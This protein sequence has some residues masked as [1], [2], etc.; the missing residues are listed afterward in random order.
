MTYHL[1]S[2]LQVD[3]EED[4]EGYIDDTVMDVDDN[5]NWAPH[6]SKT[7]CFESLSLKCEYC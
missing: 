3:D 4:E 7:V 1:S 6:G 2:G 5:D